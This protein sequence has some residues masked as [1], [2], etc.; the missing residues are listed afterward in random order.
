MASFVA[1][2]ELI[3]KPLDVPISEV[4]A[5]GTNTDHDRHFGPGHVTA[6]ELVNGCRSPAYREQPVVFTA[7]NVTQAP[8]L[9]E[10]A[11]WFTSKKSI[12]R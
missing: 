12:G 10:L 2:P 9:H 8:G 7:C 3:A 4:S 1:A 5:A 6:I 11:Q